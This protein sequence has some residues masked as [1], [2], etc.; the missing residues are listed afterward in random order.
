MKYI[1]ATFFLFSNGSEFCSF[2]PQ[3]EKKHILHCST[4][5]LCIKS[6]TVQIMQ[7]PAFVFFKQIKQRYRPTH[8]LWISTLFYS[9]KKC[10]DLW[11]RIDDSIKSHGYIWASM[12]T[13]KQKHKMHTS[14]SPGSDSMHTAIK[15]YYLKSC[16]PCWLSKALMHTRA[17]SLQMQRILG[18]LS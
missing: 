16:S 11:L 3:L 4:N 12:L 2:S 10:H 6:N 8:T 13:I 9:I 7:I 5:L 17:K 18:A 14:D 15:Q 1:I